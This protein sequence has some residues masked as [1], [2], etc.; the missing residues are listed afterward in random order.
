[1]AEAGRLCHFDESV[2]DFA[3]GQG[4]ALSKLR[5]RMSTRPTDASVTL[6]N[7]FQ[8]SPKAKE[9][10]FPSADTGST[11][12]PPPKKNSDL[13]ARFCIPKDLPLGFGPVNNFYAS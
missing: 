11:P 2:P 7:P 4:A 1:M 8:V 13:K 9:R 12:V 10:R 3:E 6:T 5:Q